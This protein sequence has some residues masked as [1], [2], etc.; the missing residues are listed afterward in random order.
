[1]QLCTAWT[2]NCL[3]FGVVDFVDF[4][5]EMVDNTKFNSN[6]R[7]GVVDHFM[8]KKTGQQRQIQEKLD[9]PGGM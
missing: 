2:V 1:M 6:L 5:F 8:D 7:F 9:R 4:K 3:K